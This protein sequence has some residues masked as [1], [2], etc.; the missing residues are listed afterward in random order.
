MRRRRASGSTREIRVGGRAHLASRFPRPSS[1]QPLCWPPFPAVLLVAQAAPPTSGPGAYLQR[2]RPQRL[3][4]HASLERRHVGAWGEPATGQARGWGGGG[5]K[6]ERRG[7]FVSHSQIGQ[8]GGTRASSFQNSAR[9]QTQVRSN[10]G[11]TYIVNQTHGIL[12]NTVHWY[13]V[14]QYPERSQREKVHCFN[15]VSN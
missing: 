4:L 6:R 8:S 7:G 15:I 13:S 9:S 12:Y 5:E 2:L 3:L 11:W 14:L 10:P 1:A